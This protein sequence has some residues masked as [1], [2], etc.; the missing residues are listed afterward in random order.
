MESSDLVYH[1][2]LSEIYSDKKSKIEDSQNNIFYTEKFKLNLIDNILKSKNLSLFDNQK[3]E[4]YLDFAVV[5]LKDN[6][7]LGSDITIDFEDSLF[8]NN[9]N[10][11]RLKGNSLFAEK[12]NTTIYKGSFTT[13]NQ[14]D[15]KCPP[16][17]MYADEVVHKKNEKKIEYKNA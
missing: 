1:R 12:N 5:N 7:F 2:N 8:G 11:P 9:E 3:N 17:S 15:N 14:K 13:R 10:D 4:Y 16:W 6:E